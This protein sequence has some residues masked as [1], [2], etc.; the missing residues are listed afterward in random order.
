M[1]SSSHYQGSAYSGLNGDATIN[2]I[3]ESPLEFISVASEFNLPW[4][5]TMPET[6]LCRV[7]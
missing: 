2:L 3:Q 6:Y 4:L 7:S 1:L 5:K